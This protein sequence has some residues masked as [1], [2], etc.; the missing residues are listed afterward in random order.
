[1]LA[2]AVTFCRVLAISFGVDVTAQMD[3]EA[4]RIVPFTQRRGE[5]SGGVPVSP[6]EVLAAA[7]A[8]WIRR[9]VLDSNGVVIDMGRTQRLFTGDAR[10]AAHMDRSRC[11]WPGCEV[12]AHRC[13]TDH[14]TDW[15][16]QGRTR[17]ADGAPACPRHNLFEQNSGYRAERHPDGSIHTY[18]AD[19]SEVA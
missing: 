16:H 8:G 3:E 15:Q 1:V 9:V 7:V 6:N 11:F 17:P 13:Q 19:G 14:L 10:I 4:A 5:T 18:R 12:P 2:D